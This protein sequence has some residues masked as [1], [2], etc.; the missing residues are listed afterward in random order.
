[1]E[2]QKT[3]TNLEHIESV[4]HAKETL[5]NMFENGNC[6]AGY[7]LA[8]FYREHG[9]YQECFDLAMQVF[10]KISN[11]N[12]KESKIL[13]WKIDMEIS[14]VAYYCEG[15]R[16][17]G[18]RA[19]KR[20]LKDAI[21]IPQHLQYIITTTRSNYKYYL[22]LDDEDNPNNSLLDSDIT[23]VSMYLDLSKFEERRK[24]TNT[25]QNPGAE[26]LKQKVPMILF[27]D[28]TFAEKPQR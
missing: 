20:I 28:D 15:L 24:N 5:F 3:L 7:E 17:Y 14:I 2:L 18:L 23:V 22:S 9:K 6:C 11:R 8:K 16:K 10:D 19:C 26:F 27:L 21:Q 4:Q 13:R 12:D 25:Y 1:M